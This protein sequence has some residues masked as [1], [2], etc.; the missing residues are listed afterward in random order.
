IF[1]P[2]L[3]SLGAHSLYW[4]N[5]VSTGGRTFAVL[6][7]MLGSLPFAEK[8]FLEQGDA[9][10]DHIT[11]ASILEKNGYS[12]NFYYG[13]DEHFDNMDVFMK[14]NGVTIHDIKSFDNSYLLLP[15][16][17]S[18][19]SWGYEDRELFRHYLATLPDDNKPRLDI[20]LTVANHSP[21]LI[22]NQNYYLNLFEA[23]LNT[24]QFT[25]DHPRDDYEQYKMKYSCIMYTDN[26]IRYFINEYSKKP[27]FKNTIFIITGDH[28]MPEIPIATLIDRFH[29]P[30]IIYSPML[31]KGVRFKGVSAQFDVTPTL[32]SYLAKNYGLKTPSVVSW[33]GDLLDTYPD[34]RCI[35]SYP[36][37]RN[38]NELL[39]YLDGEYFMAE[40]Q[41]FKLSNNMGIDAIDDPT[42][43]SLI[44]AKFDLY[45]IN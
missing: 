12:T 32:L 2:F 19:P 33:V 26:S 21:F 35:K 11:L 29:V 39:D 37:M 22:H 28:R 9:M 38:K 25:S 8:G 17:G 16:E 1:T 15:S 10:P 31:K 45:K 30:L 20:L 44:K 4:S 27:S 42:K 7:S 23:K 13:G 36:L 40:N 18:N 41:L 3:D 14:R 43:A 34:F 5:F 6:P 24:M